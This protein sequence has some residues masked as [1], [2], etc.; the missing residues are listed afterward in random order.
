MQIALAES[1]LLKK[2]KEL[3]KREKLIKSNIKDLKSKTI[4]KKI[5][6]TFN[7]N[8]KRTKKKKKKKV[9]RIKK[10]VKKFK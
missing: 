9:K 6:I 7:P 2:Q 8:A 10:S 4:K 3:I 1:S 5:P